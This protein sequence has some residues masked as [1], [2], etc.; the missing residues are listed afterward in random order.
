MTENP[1][2]LPTPEDLGMKKFEVKFRIGKGGVMEKAVFIGDEE[3]DWQIDISSYMDASKMGPMFKREI[4]RD[5]ELHFCESVGDFLGRKVTIDE[6][7]TAI[8]TG[9]I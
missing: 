8:K 6:I 1:D 4:Q 9:W 5:I 3:L 2:N 7:K